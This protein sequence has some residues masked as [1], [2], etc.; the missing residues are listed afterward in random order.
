MNR[1]F[2]SLLLVCAGLLA[3]AGTPFAQSASRPP[4]MT[5]GAAAPAALPDWDHLSPAQRD[6]I[7]S[8]LRDRWNG[9]PAQR[10]RMLQ[11]AE[12]WRQ[13]TPDQRRQAM[14][15]QHRWEQMSPEERERAMSAYRQSRGQ[16]QPPRGGNLTPDQQRELQDDLRALPQ[17]DRRGLRQEY[18]AMTPEQREQMRRQW[19]SMT[20]E[21]RREWLRNRRQR[22]Q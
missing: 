9:N 5:P 2:P 6:A 1:S 17:A 20:P 12:R 19:E 4:P 22:S 3:P 8:V 7:V 14:H 11:H 13:M 10:T 15:G 16:G 18:K 21:Q